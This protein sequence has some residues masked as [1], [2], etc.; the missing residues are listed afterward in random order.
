MFNP[1]K[2]EKEFEEKVVQV[3]RVSKKTKGENRIGF[4][5]LMVVGDKKGRVGIGLGKATDVSSAIRK[6]STYAQKRLITVAMKGTTIPHEIRIKLGAA[7]LMLKPAPAGSGVIAGG[8]VRAIVEAAGIKDVI[9]KILG[10][11]NRASNVY[12]TFEAL[13]RLKNRK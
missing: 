2:I 6:G 9:G 8:P 12:A 13:K 1:E 5:A 7:K 11:S 4:S 10:T 3:N